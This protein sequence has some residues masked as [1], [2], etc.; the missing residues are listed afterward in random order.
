[1]RT[2][3]GIGSVHKTRLSVKNPN[4][5]RPTVWFASWRQLAGV[6][7]DGNRKLLCLIQ[8]HKPRTVMELA[9]LSGACGK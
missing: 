2:V 5:P 4:D 8:E 3:V 1:M 6:L 7:S 9:E